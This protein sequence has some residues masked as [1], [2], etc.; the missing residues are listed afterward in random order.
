VGGAVQLDT[1]GGADLIA[2]FV[3]PAV[4]VVNGMDGSKACLVSGYGRFLT[5]P[6]AGVFGG[7]T[8]GN[9]TGTDGVQIGIDGGTS[10]T[11]YSAV[12]G[13]VPGSPG[14]VSTIP[15]DLGWHR[16]RLRT[17]AGG[18]LVWFSVDGEAPQSFACT[19]VDPSKPVVSLFD[20]LSPQSFQWSNFVI[21]TDQNA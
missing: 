2:M 16:F 14:V 18:A 5:A 9:N 13:I 17:T 4:C 3:S 10:P 20:A 1:G 6:D 21:V 19:Y 15:I 12:H 7:F 11:N 8:V